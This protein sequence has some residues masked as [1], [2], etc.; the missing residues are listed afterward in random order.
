MERYFGHVEMRTSSRGRTEAIINFEG[1]FGLPP[2]T[3]VAVFEVSEA[4]PLST[5]TRN[6][7]GRIV[8]GD[9]VL[10]DYELQMAEHVGALGCIRGRV[11]L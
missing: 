5:L 2:G 11:V 8:R 1:D 3:R 4:A 9:H 10:T 6:E 7:D